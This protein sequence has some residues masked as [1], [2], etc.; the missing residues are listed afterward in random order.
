MASSNMIRILMIVSAALMLV[1][2]ALGV[3]TGDSLYLTLAA[4]F[5]LPAA[6]GALLHRQRNLEIAAGAALPP[7]ATV[8]RNAVWAGLFLA[9]AGA[10]GLLH[11]W[12][13]DSLWTPTLLLVLLFLLFM[14]VHYA[15]R[16]TRQL[17]SP[18][19]PST[20]P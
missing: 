3:W 13:L 17:R 5:A 9:G 20:G 19:S 11:E 15:S 2:L 7:E 10:I 8:A 4:S 1:T 12:S 6:V 14:G 16:L 18:R